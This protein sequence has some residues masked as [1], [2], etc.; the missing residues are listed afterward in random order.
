MSR[1]P[2]LMG[3]QAIRFELRDTSQRDPLH[4]PIDEPGF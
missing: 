4:L 3:F 2:D 1:W